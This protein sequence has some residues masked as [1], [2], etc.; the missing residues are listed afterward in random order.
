MVSKKKSRM[1]FE[2]SGELERLM[3]D[4]GGASRSKADALRHAINIVRNYERNVR[5]S[6]NEPLNQGMESRIFFEERSNLGPRLME[7]R[8]ALDEVKRPRRRANRKTPSP[9]KIFIS[10]A[11]EDLKAAR[12]IYWKLRHRG[13]EPWMDDYSLTKGVD[14]QEEVSKAISTSE[15]FVAVLSKASVSKTGFVQVEVHKASEEQLK[16]PEG[17]VYFIPFKIDDCEV[18]KKLNKLNYI[19]CTTTGKPYMQLIEAVESVTSKI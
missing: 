19:D 7:F 6:S 13:H 11:R 18:P 3:E 12:K 14:W 2:I 16:R 17:V 5:F 9:A 4:I 1:S 8:A 10:Y 15:F